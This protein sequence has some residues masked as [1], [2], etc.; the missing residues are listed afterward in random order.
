MLLWYFCCLCTG[1]ILP[2]V[3]CSTAQSMKMW[4]K[5]S[6]TRG[7]MPESHSW[8]SDLNIVQLAL[9]RKSV[10][11]DIQCLYIWIHQPLNKC[12]NQR[13]RTKFLCCK[14]DHHPNLPP[15]AI[16]NRIDNTRVGI[17]RKG[18]HE[19]EGPPSA[20]DA[21]FSIGR[22][23]IEQPMTLV[24]PRMIWVWFECATWISLWNFC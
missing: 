9:R 17:I 10:T 4:Y 23:K 19:V 20:K 11:R 14:N 8:W 2:L 12:F 15:A 24:R 18:S 5:Q 7:R 1:D 13:W 16:E 6:K 21:N 3:G 22:I